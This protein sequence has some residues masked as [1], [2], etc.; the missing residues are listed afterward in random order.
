M[1]LGVL[2]G[3]ENSA[4]KLPILMLSQWPELHVVFFPFSIPVTYE[5]LQS[6][7]TSFNTQTGHLSSSIKKI[8]L[9]YGSYSL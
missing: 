3:Y 6:K 1:Y 4:Y 2:Q 5:N 7:V 8:F 9:Q